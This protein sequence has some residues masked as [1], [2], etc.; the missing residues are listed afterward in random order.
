MPPFTIKQN[1]EIR[2][3]SAFRQ[4]GFTSEPSEEEFQSFSLDLPDGAAVLD[5]KIA[6][7]GTVWGDSR[8]YLLDARILGTMVD[9]PTDVYTV[10]A[11]IIRRFS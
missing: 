8:F 6:M 4:Q 7:H 10:G 2:S 5:I 3:V 9:N 1:R 11:P